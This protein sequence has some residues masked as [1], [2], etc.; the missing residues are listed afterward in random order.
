MNQVAASSLK[1]QTMGQ[2]IYD[3]ETS[4][5]KLKWEI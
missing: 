3:L 2:M 5:K 4:E 1:K